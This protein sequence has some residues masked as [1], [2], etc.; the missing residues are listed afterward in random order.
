MRYLA[1]ANLDELR[2]K[3]DERSTVVEVIANL[4]SRRRRRSTA[5]ERSTGDKYW[6]TLTSFQFS[7]T[8]IE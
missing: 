4:Q 6:R 7:S 3:E 2:E 1:R 8:G 5:V